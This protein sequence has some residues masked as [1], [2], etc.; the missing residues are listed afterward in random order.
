MN[1]TESAARLKAMKEIERA[2][3]HYKLA[4]FSAVAFEAAL[5]A[6]ML[7][8]MDPKDRTHVLLLL[9]FVGSYTIVVLALFALGAHVNRVGQRILRALADGADDR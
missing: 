4:F 2:E 6:G 3:R 8:L 7:L 5:L 9:G 1:T